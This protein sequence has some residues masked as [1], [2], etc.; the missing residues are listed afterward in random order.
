MPHRVAVTCSECAGEAVF[1][2]AENVRIKTNA[3]L[4]W[5]QNSKHFECH[6]MEDPNGQSYNVATYYHKLAGNDLPAV[7][8]LPAGYRMEDWAHSDRKFRPLGDWR[9]TL[10]C[11]SCG[12]RRKHVLDWPKEAFYQVEY[13]NHTLW[14]F[15]RASVLE[16]AEFIDASQRKPDDFTYWPFLMK[17][18]Q[19][20][21]TKQARET[22]VKRLR[23]RLG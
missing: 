23:K 11:A 18:P 20:F 16:L 17:I 13:R 12:V 15:D 1:E 2:F 6:K 19:V 14:A 5:F 3:D 22:V 4:G 9:G 10:I 21:L 7:G 8:D